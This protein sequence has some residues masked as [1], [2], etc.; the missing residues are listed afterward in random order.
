MPT[1]NF[2]KGIDIAITEL[3]AQLPT[4]TTALSCMTTAEE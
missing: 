2:K 1:T 4:A 3:M